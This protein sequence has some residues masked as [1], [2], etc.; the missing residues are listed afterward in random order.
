MFAYEIWEK[1]KIK[2]K[3]IEN[4]GY[5][6]LIIWEYDYKYHKEETI[7]KCIEFLNS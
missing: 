2:I 1:E 7:Q 5:E 4:L 3:S 6:V